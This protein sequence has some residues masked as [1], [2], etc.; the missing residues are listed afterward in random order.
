MQIIKIWYTKSITEAY[1]INKE[2]QWL[3][4]WKHKNPVQV[5]PYM[6]IMTYMYIQQYVM[7]GIYSVIARVNKIVKSN[8]LICTCPLSKSWCEFSILPHRDDTWVIK[9]RHREWDLLNITYG[10]KYSNV[11]F[12]S[13]HLHH[14][15]AKIIIGNYTYNWKFR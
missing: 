11:I 6:L 14:P 8:L 15:P 13:V 3:L 7:Y 10:S 9:A 12:S 1:N 2:Y 4:V 5:F